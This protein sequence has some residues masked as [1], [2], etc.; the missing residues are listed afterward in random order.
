[1]S[2]DR[3]QSRDRE[4]ADHRRDAGATHRGAV[5]HALRAFTLTEMMVALA[6]TIFVLAV[7]TNVFSI[8]ARTA[9]TSAAI[10]DVEAVARNFADQI[11]QD[12]DACDPAESILVI[13]G[14]TIPAALTPDTLQ[15]RQFYR[16]LTGDPGY[17]T[18]GYDTRFDSDPA[19]TN[20]TNARDQYSDPRADILMFFSKRP[21]IS[22]APATSANLPLGSF[23]QKLQNGTRVSPVQIV[24]GHAALDSA[25][26]SGSTWAFADNLRHIE[27]TSGSPPM[28][29]VPASQWHLAR[30]V[31]LLDPNSPFP[32]PSGGWGFKRDDFPRVLRCYD[33]S[34]GGGLTTVAGDSVDL[35]FVRYLVQFQPRYVGGRF[36]LATLSPYA[37]RPYPNFVPPALYW[38]A[39]ND[40]DLIDD[41]LYPSGNTTYHHVATVIE[42]PPAALQSNLGVQLV[43]GCVWFQVE[44]LMPEDPRNGLDSPL[45]DQRRDTPRWV[46]VDNGATY[47]FV[48]DSEE[49]RQ[50][51]ENQAL[52]APFGVSTLPQRVATFMQVV[53]PTGTTP[54]VNYAGLDTV[55]NR[56]VRMW[57]YAIRVTIRVTDPHGRLA[58]PIV[59]TVVHRFD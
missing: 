50:F 22:R 10:A 3:D 15:A 20:G 19:A 16:V 32:Q 44:F 26:R 45:S 24:Y 13:H 27:Q 9:S 38:R 59:R 41:V 1:M 55:A 54:P 49:N 33:D 47:V 29:I 7:V 31:L 14:R 42:N 28:S 35:D 51:I 58:E 43:P 46:Q 34:G 23:E 56:R 57:P 2:R 39:Q 30:R 18:A 4:G 12:L 40:R 36:S 21:S 37:F 11:E 17:V 53:P 52:A 8:T 48:P 25:V 6:V 5:C